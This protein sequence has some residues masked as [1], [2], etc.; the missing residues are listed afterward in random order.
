MNWNWIWVEINQKTYICWD[1]RNCVKTK[2]K[3]KLCQTMVSLIPKSFISNFFDSSSAKTSV[4]ANYYQINDGLHQN[5]KIVIS[6]QI[7]PAAQRFE[8]NLICGKTVTKELIKYGDI[9]LQ[10]SVNPSGGY[11]SLNSRLNK[12]WGKE[13][14][15]A[16]GRLPRPL[17]QNQ[18]FTLTITVD[19]TCFQIQVNDR[20]F[21]SF[22]HRMPFNSIGLVKCDGDATIANLEIQTQVTLD[23]MQPM[24]ALL[25]PPYQAS[26]AEPDNDFGFDHVLY[27]ITYPPL[28]CLQSIKCGLQPGMIITITARIL[29]NRFDLGLYQGSNPYEDP[30]NDVAFHMEVYVKEMSIVR[31]SYQSNK[32]MQMERYLE[33]FPFVPNSNFK[34]TIRIES[35]RYMVSANNRHLFDFYHRVLPLNTIDYLC[36]HGGLEIQTITVMNPPL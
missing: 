29:D 16:R 31:N 14:R 1:Q 17:L 27:N 9:A 19:N 28:P 5:S 10:F 4:S 8:V 32:W 35:N 34:L 7:R 25:P 24:P 33:G 26:A 2:G 6:G 13:D 23:Q 11:A 18:K 22:A 3:Q 36:I 12:I 21:L 30:V 15:T 20:P